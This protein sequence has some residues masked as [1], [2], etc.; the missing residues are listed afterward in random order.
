[1]SGNQMEAMLNQRYTQD[2]SQKRNN[3]TS[4]SCVTMSERSKK[5]RMNKIFCAK[6]V[7]PT[8]KSGISRKTMMPQAPRPVNRQADRID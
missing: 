6:T 4:L 5:T 1:M 3:I 8:V 2:R 7:A